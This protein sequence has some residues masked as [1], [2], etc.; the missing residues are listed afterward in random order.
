MSEIL[1][2]P[3]LG[4]EF[5][6]NRV[7]FSVG[8]RPVYWYG[9][10]IALAFLAAASYVLTRTR[11]F[12]L[13]NDRVMDVILGAVVLGIIGA[14]LYYVAFEWDTYA[15]NPISII[16]IREGGI[17]IY[18]G[19]IGGAIAMAVMCKWRAV[20]LLP[21]L[22]LAAGGLFIGQAI[23]RWGNFVNMEAFGSNTTVVWGMTSPSISWYLSRNM[24]RLSQIGVTV[25]PGM[26]V[27]PTFLYES[28]WCFLGFLAIAWF[29]N[30]RRFDGELILIYLGWYGL[31]RF[32]I[33]GLRTDSLMLGTMR[34][35]QIVALLCVLASVLW[36]SL[37]L[38]KIRRSNDP[39][40]MKLHVETDEGKAVLAGEFYKK[41]DSAEQTKPEEITETESE[42]IVDEEPGTDTDSSDEEPEP[43]AAEEELA[44]EN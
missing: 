38:S 43:E 35:S 31:G 6:L 32:F 41:K 22:D 1:S 8:G 27:H 4:L 28:L 25:D 19:I 14:R 15:K 7:A 29:T 17:A 10:I 11:A 13:D 26:P 20:K 21:M 30:R 9:I 34:I 24:S 36:L 42:N 33:E 40:F 3:A 39:E 18:G 5:E 37:T 12:G 23:G 16:N 2:F 44:D